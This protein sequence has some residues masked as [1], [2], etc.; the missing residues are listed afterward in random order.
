[1]CLRLLFANSQYSAKE[2][3]GGGE[4]LF[5]SCHPAC[6]SSVPV[7]QKKKKKKIIIIIIIMM[8]MMM[9]MIIINKRENKGDVNSLD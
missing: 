5:A 8:M 2:F 1:M 7:Q 4:G 6:V 3:V 9:M